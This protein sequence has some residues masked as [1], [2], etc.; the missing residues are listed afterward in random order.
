MSRGPFVLAT[1]SGP[2]RVALYRCLAGDGRH[3]ISNQANC[4]GDK[5]D[6]LLGYGFQ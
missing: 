4:E 5:V 1:N 6:T 2:G 3:F